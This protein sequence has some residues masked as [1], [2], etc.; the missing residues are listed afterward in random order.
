M[1]LLILIYIFGTRCVR[2]AHDDARTGV[3]VV[4]RRAAEH[5]HARDEQRIVR[6]EVFG[7]NQRQVHVTCIP[8][9]DEL[10]GGI[11][12]GAFGAEEDTRG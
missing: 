4:L 7:A 9:G 5:I 2:E 10:N 3:K 1:V 11:R 6:A 12:R 8:C